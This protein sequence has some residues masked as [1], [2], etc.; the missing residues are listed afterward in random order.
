MHTRLL[1]NGAIIV[2]SFP[3][4]A[5]TTSQIDLKYEYHTLVRRSSFFYNN[6]NKIM[7]DFIYSG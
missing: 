1:K 4:I 5:A 6:N 2:P 7:I 3:M